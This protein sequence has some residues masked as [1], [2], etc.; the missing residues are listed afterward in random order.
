MKAI[1]GLL[2]G[3]HKQQAINCL[4][5]QIPITSTLLLHPI[6]QFMECS[7][8]RQCILVTIKGSYMSP[9]VKQPLPTHVIK[10]F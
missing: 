8:V 7:M 6:I 3:N 10:K 2:L 4:H 1:N 9:Q 5:H